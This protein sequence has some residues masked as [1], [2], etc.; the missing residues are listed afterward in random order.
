MWPGP[1]P[2]TVP[3]D[4]VVHPTVLPQYTTDRQ[5][6][7]RSD[8]IGRTVFTNGHPKTVNDIVSALPC[9]ETTR[10]NS[11]DVVMLVFFA[12][13]LDFEEGRS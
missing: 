1:R 2:S 13:L 4:I 11:V 3:S 8:S 6:R 9:G 10:D 12:S 7:Q 5:D